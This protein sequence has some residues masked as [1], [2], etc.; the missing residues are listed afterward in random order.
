MKPDIG[1]ELRFLPT[2]PAFALRGFP[3]E[4][5]HDVWYGKTRMVWL[6]DGEKMLK[7]IF[8]PIC[9]DRIHERDRRTDGQTDG[10]TDGHRMTA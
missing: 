2:P 7:I 3:S 9:F 6:P 8:R 5:R 10:Q 4:Y 1:S